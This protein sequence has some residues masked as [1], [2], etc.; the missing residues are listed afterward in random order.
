M[1]TIVGFDSRAAIE[2]QAREWLVRLDGDTPL[3]DDER[4]TLRAWMA[5]SSQHR[6]ELTRLARFW[7]NANV[8]TELAV[9]LECAAD[10]GQPRDHRV[11]LF[12]LAASVIIA[13]VIAGAWWWT[14]KHPF[15][16][17]GAY[18]TAI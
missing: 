12:A 2:R 7:N 9:P 14:Q 5:R 11:K 10:R 8:L 15:A 1:S 17:N 18:G 6:E 3:S 13:S 4:A 16:A